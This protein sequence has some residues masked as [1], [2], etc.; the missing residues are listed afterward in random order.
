M[1]AQPW[2]VPNAESDRIRAEA[3]SSAPL[4]FHVS[5]IVPVTTLRTIYL[6]GKNPTLCFLEFRQK[7]AFFLREILHQNMCN[8]NRVCGLADFYKLAFQGNLKLT[9]I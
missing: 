4:K 6:G 8:R 1:P 3:K 7:R 5:N 2:A 9:V